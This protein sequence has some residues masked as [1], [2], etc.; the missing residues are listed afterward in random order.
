MAS[1]QKIVPLQTVPEIRKGW[2]YICSR[3]SHQ[4]GV[5]LAENLMDAGKCPIVDLKVSV[6]GVIKIIAQ[7]LKAKVG[8]GLRIS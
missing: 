1:D 4:A 2:Q 3:A 7:F 5:K 6:P 8:G